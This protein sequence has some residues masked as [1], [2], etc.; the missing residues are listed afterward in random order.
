LTVSSLDDESLAIDAPEDPEPFQNETLPEASAPRKTVEEVLDCFIAEALVSP[1]RSYVAQWDSELTDFMNNPKATQHEFPPMNARHRE[2]LVRVA[3][4]FNLVYEIA[5]SLPGVERLGMTLFKNLNSQVPDR[6]LSQIDKDTLIAMQLISA[7]SAQP[8]VA[9]RAQP[10]PKAAAPKVMIM[11]RAQRSKE[12]IQAAEL[13]KL[14]TLTVKSV[15]ER[16]RDY[17]EART[18]LGLDS[19]PQAPRIQ[20][21]SVNKSSNARTAQGGLSQDGGT[22]DTRGFGGRGRGKAARGPGGGGVA[23]GPPQRK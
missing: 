16:E 23:S 17:N 15:E 18:R 12:D 7:R 5:S 11:K 4:S 6:K 3:H 10:A 9:Q 22:K 21:K 13:A 19:T 2:M 20:S 8:V 1:D 14:N